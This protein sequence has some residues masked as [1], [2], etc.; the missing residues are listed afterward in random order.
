[1]QSKLPGHL[2]RDETIAK[3]PGMA[4]LKPENWLL[5]D[6]AYGPQM[7]LRDRLIRARA[8]DVLAMEP[9]A[10]AAASELLD[11]VID[12]LKLDPG[13]QVSDGAVIRPDGVKIA[14]NRAE[15][16][17]TAG[18]LVQED[19]CLM[20]RR[21]D[22]HVL[23][24]AV[25]CF[26][27]GWTL[28]EKMRRPLIGIHRPVAQYN[29]DTAKRVQRLFDAIKP[30]RPLWRANGFYYDTPELFAPFTEAEPRPK[31]SAMAGYFRAERQC[32]LRLPVSGAVVFSIH[33]YMIRRQDLSPVQA[34]L[35]Q[36]VLTKD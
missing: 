16:L 23:T 17:A 36:R 5:V 26:P 20:Q 14:L 1:M 32:L 27:A 11:Q 13:Y 8:G 35:A 3:L 22:A 7:A 21:G 25:L 2:W 15:P 6:D 31:I 28:A 30:G 33:T 4:P 18:R 10:L 34:D 24:G 29:A 12:A 19:L 9:S